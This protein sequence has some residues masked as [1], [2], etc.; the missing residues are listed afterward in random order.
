MPR[1]ELERLEQALSAG[2]LAHARTEVESW[3]CEPRRFVEIQNLSGLIER[4]EER[5][6]AAGAPLRIALLGDF[7]THPVRIVLRVVGLML[8]RRVSIHEADYDTYRV[9]ILNRQSAL[10]AFRPEVAILATSTAANRVWP[11]PGAGEEE[12]RALAGSVIEGLETL[13]RSLRESSGAF[14]VQHAFEPPAFGEP[15][16]RGAASRP[17]SATGFTRRLNEALWARDG[18]GMRVLDT[19][20]LATRAGSWNWTDPRLYFHSK[21][22]FHPNAAG[23]YALALAGLLRAQAGRPRKVMVTD[24]DNTLWGGTIGDDGPEGIAFSPETAVGEAHLSYARYLASLRAR[25]ILLGVCS[26]NMESAAREG[27]ARPGLPLKLED[28]AAFTANFEPKAANL[29]VMAERL[30]VGLDSFVFADDDAVEC[31]AVRE[32]VPEVTVVPMRGDPSG[33]ARRLERLALFEPLDFTA[34]DYSRAATET[35]R[36]QALSVAPEGDLETFLKG[37]EM[38]GA[39]RPPSA[40]EI[41][42]VEQLFRKTNQFNLTQEVFDPARIAELAGRDAALLVTELED[43]LSHYGL[44]AAVVTERRGRALE[45]LNWVM[46]CRVFSR[47][48][49]DFILRGLARE[50][51]EMG[52][53]EIGGRFGESARNGYAKAFLARV[54]GVSSGRWSISVEEALA[55]SSH[56]SLLQGDPS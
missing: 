11:R 47:S 6:E 29:R 3:L 50:A 35:V 45:V 4:H 55:L 13:W 33:F 40:S 19:E 9:E 41:A 17:W 43:R 42:R 15:A 28:F 5:L 25:G 48:V 31:A 38:R 7:T 27:F 51:S 46:S 22:A 20:A 34:E 16:G 26:K 53:T 52:A 24:L 30:N 39:L 18:H 1:P 14:V 21:H 37:L 44:I 56:V 12:A 10:H 49:E 32:A 36:Q 54:A 8:G 23:D 2:D